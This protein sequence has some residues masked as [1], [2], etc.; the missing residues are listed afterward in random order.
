[1]RCEDRYIELY[2]KAPDNVAFCPSCVM[3]HEEN[4]IP[5]LQKTAVI[6]LDELG[7]ITSYE[8]KPKEPKGNM[9]VPPF[10][11]YKAEDICRISEALEDGCGYDAS[12]SFAAWLSKKVPMHTWRMTGSRH[13]IGD[14]QSYEAVKSTYKG[15]I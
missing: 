7:M 4:S 10:Y 14:V 8:E 1:M 2:E 9:A 13:D 11:I 6:T 3:C 12:G 5:A 15:I